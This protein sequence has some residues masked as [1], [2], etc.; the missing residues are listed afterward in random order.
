M[1][2]TWHI[3]YECQLYDDLRAD[4]PTLFPLHA[5]GPPVARPDVQHQHQQLVAFFAG[6]PVE[7]ARFSAACRTRGRRAAGLPP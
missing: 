1:E 3:L 6:P 7:V 2:D 4:F 5:E